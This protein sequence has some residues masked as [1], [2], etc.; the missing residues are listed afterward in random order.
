MESK[1]AVEKFIEQLERQGNSWETL[2]MGTINISIKVDEY[3]KLKEK[4]K[5]KFEKQ[6][7][8]AHLKGQHYADGFEVPHQIVAEQYYNETFK[9]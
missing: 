3:L 4:A 8:E 5:E 2:S 6:I 1:T 7:K 9:Q